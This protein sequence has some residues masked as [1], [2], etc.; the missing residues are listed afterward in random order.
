MC[1][2]QDAV[3][4]RPAAGLQVTSQCARVPAAAHTCAH[5]APVPETRVTRWAV[6]FDLGGPAARVGVRAESCAWD[7]PGAK[8]V[9]S[10][11]DSPRQCPGRPRVPKCP[12]FAPSSC[13][14]CRAPVKGPE[15]P[16]CWARTQGTA[17]A[18]KR[19]QGLEHLLVQSPL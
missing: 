6:T 2:G 11:H 15:A 1:K 7:H 10:V 16:F 12:R 5:T 3:S 13:R 19:D 18:P 14:Q 4:P 8:A 17:A 9:L